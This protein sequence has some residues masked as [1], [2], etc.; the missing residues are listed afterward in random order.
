MNAAAIASRSWRED[1][2]RRF[3]RV[4]IKLLAGGTR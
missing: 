1:T 2:F 3:G 4:S